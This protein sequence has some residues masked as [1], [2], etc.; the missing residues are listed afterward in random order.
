VSRRGD[1]VD[2]DATQLGDQRLP[3]RLPESGTGEQ[4]RLEAADGMQTRQ[5][6]VAD[7]ALVDDDAA[8][9]GQSRS[10]GGTSLGSERRGDPCKKRAIPR[11]MVFS[12]E[13]AARASQSRAAVTTRRPP[14][15]VE[16]TFSRHPDGPLAEP[17][18]ARVYVFRDEA[19]D[20]FG[21]GGGSGRSGGGAA[22]GGE[23]GLLDGVPEYRLFDNC[24]NT[25]SIHA[26]ARALAEDETVAIGPDGRAPE[27][28]VV[29]EAGEAARL[30]EVVTRLVLDEGVRPEQ[31]A[32]LTA[33]R[34]WLGALAPFRR[35]GEYPVTDDT[36]GVPGHVL[37]GW[38]GRW[39]CWPGCGSRRC[40]WTRRSCCTWG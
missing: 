13:R 34:R 9:V 40:T 3:I 16:A 19:Q 14:A 12:G 2:R 39:W 28:I 36:A 11:R 38:S 5:Q 15:D 21:G 4:V 7:L 26:V 20:V 31:I 18:T 30:A 22:G 27:F 6:V 8:A 33:A 1:T 23:A 17:A 29:D 35:I 25:R 37:L 24:R 32:V 10:D